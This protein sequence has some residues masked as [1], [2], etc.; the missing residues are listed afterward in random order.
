MR[1]QAS[2]TITSIGIVRAP[3]SMTAC[4]VYASK[5]GFGG[6]NRG[7]SVWYLSDTKVFRFSIDDAGHW[8]TR[9]ADK[10]LVDYTDTGRDL[11]QKMKAKGG[12]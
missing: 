2:M 4:L 10:Q 9:C 7:Y 1:D 5:N 11:L 8:N 12:S 3:K 6:M